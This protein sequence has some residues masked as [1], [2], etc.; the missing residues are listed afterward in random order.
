MN[1]KLYNELLEKLLHS[2]LSKR[3]FCK[4]YNIPHAW[5]IEFMNPDKVFRPLQV[6]TQAL[7]V[8]NLG[9]PYEYTVEYNEIIKKERSV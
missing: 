3:G 9:I 7:L 6:K 2:G 4:K 5:F 1:T 8:N